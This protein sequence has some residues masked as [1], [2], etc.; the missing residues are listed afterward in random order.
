MKIIYKLEENSFNELNIIKKEVPEKYKLTDKDWEYEDFE[1]AK[2]RLLEE[3]NRQVDS[4]ADQIEF[5]SD[6]LED[7]VQEKADDY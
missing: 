5:I 3:L 2:E 4:L 6:L 7:E 1:E